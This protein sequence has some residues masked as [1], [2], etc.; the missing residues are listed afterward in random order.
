MTLGSLPHE[1]K[2]GRI[3]RPGF[4]SNWGEIV[5]PMTAQTENGRARQNP[6]LMRFRLIGWSTHRS[7]PNAST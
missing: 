3:K 4:P 6:T 7:N 1:R 2:R 5:V